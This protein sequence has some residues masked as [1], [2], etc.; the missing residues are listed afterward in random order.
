MVGVE[1]TEIE[2]G[3][4]VILGHQISI[5]KSKEVKETVWVLEATQASFWS[6]CDTSYLSTGAVDPRQR[7]QHCSFVVAHS[8]LSRFVLNF[9]RVF[10]EASPQ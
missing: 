4:S 8:S 2:K 5:F 6:L 10:R 1:E 7:R 9:E 3:L